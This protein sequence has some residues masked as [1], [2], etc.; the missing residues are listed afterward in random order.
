[1]K[2]SVAIAMIVAFGN[3][4]GLIASYTYV[5]P[6]RR[7][8]PIA[9]TVFTLALIIDTYQETR[10]DTILGTVRDLVFLIA[11]SISELCLG[12]LVSVLVVSA[13]QARS[14]LF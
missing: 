14:L 13:L 10:L 5:H 6:S 2:R 12:V 4:G 11:N 9:P 3:L 1:M 7:S 8:Q